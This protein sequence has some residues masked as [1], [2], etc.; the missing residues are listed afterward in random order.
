MYEILR[1]FALSAFVSMAVWCCYL[2]F[3]LLLFNVLCARCVRDFLRFAV[4]A[5]IFG[6]IAFTAILSRFHSIKIH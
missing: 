5:H 1:L 2:A 3:L 6:G 4:F